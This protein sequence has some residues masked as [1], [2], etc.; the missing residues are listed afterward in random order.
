MGNV[1]TRWMQAT[2]DPSEALI[3]FVSCL[4]SNKNAWIEIRKNGDQDYPIMKKNPLLDN[5]FNWTSAYGVPRNEEEMANGQYFNNTEKDMTY[6]WIAA[7]GTEKAIE[8][9]QKNGTITEGLMNGGGISHPVRIKDANAYRRDIIGDNY[10]YGYFVQYWK[11]KD[12]IKYYVVDD[13]IDDV[14]VICFDDGPVDKTKAIIRTAR[15]LAAYA[16][17]YPANPKVEEDNGIWK[18]GVAYEHYGYIK[19]TKDEAA[20]EQEAIEVARKK[21]DEITIVELE[22]I[23]EP[24]AETMEIDTEGVLEM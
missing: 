24:L 6:N 23:T 22:N 8:E 4:E 14:F 20:T 5:P 3:G 21:L 18:V 12:G 1:S 10:K 7:F 17:K 13:S 9:Y 15:F 19:V 11:P 16:D 2:T